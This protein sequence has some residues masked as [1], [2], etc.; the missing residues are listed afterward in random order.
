MINK[1]TKNQLEELYYSKKTREVCK[2]LGVSL[3]TL[4][5]YIKKLG[6]SQKPKGNY[7]NSDKAKI[8]IIK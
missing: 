2:E 8:T 6:I 1:L 3:P 7:D 4:I 5:K